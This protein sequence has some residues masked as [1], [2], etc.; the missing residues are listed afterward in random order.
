MN[1]FGSFTQFISFVR[2]EFRHILRDRRTLMILLIMP[3]ILLIL[4]GF[5]LS[6]EVRNVRVGIY[7]PS[8]DAATL[9]LTN[10]IDASAQFNITM[11]ESDKDISR[12]FQQ[13]A[14]DLAIVY[15]ENFYQR[16]LASSN[17]SIQIIADGSNTNL[18]MMGTVYLQGIISAYQAEMMEEHLLDE[19]AQASIQLLSKDLSEEEIAEA[20]GTMSAP[21]IPVFI[22]TDSRMLYNPQLKSSFNFVPGVMGLIFMI[23]CAMMTSISIVREKQRGTME[24]LLVSP[25][26]PSMII[27]AKAIPYFAISLVNYTTIILM[28]TA[29]LHVPIA[30]SFFWLTI[31]SLLYI[32]V[33][34]TIGIM[35]S[36]VVSSQE[37]A[38]LIAGV[39]LM[40]PT[41]MLSGMLFP[42]QSMP[43]W[44]QY[45]SCGIPATWYID[46][47]KNIMICGLDVSS[48]FRQIVILCGFEAL[49]IGIS[50][51]TFKTRL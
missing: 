29:V 21:V 38:V 27:L 36:T 4:F 3:V 50:L 47:A 17:A 28:A 19:A 51:F 41:I 5:A 11:L 33:A 40:L 8:N 10:Q 37:V 45:A 1:N 32:I 23:I 14:I 44:L 7:D 18:A 49:F 12:L 9:R 26:K 39:I 13:N 31:I 30:G 42:I 22:D 43:V 15:E 46:C 34:L 24:V 6:T 20:A 35:I 16:I 2:K 48:C 25:V